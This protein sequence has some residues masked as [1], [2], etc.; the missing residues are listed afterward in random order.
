MRWRPYPGSTAFDIPCQMAGIHLSRCRSIAKSA[1]F[2]YEP[3][4]RS[5]QAG[6]W[7]DS[8]P[9]QKNVGNRNSASVLTATNTHLFC[10]NNQTFQSIQRSES[11]ETASFLGLGRCDLHDYGHGH[12]LQAEIRERKDHNECLYETGLLCGWC[13]VWFFWHQAAVQ[14]GRQESLCPWPRPPACG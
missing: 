2:A 9:V 8:R 7:H 6:V 3:V 12:R 1:K 14:Q 11:D 10:Y 5:I 13:V 4:Q